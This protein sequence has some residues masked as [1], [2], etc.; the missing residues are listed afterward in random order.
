MMAPEDCALRAS[1]RVLV[2]T[3]PG[4]E[5]PGNEAVWLPADVLARAGSDATAINRS[6]EPT[7]ISR[8]I[9]TDERGGVIKCGCAERGCRLKPAFHC[10]RNAGFSRQLRTHFQSHPPELRHWETAFPPCPPLILSRRAKIMNTRWLLPT[11]LLTTLHPALADGPADN[12]PGRVRRVPPRGIPVAAADRAELETG[13][14]ELGLQIESLRKE[15]EAKPARLDLLAD[16]QIYHKAVRYALAYDEFFNT[17]EISV[18]KALLAQ[19]RERAESLRDGKAPW[20]AATGLV[21]RG[22]TSRID[23]SV[24]PYG[25]VIPPSYQ[26]NTAH[27]F[28]RDWWLHGRGETLREQR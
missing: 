19:G 26:P 18:A 23:G 28:R 25:L 17:N 8:P 10:G 16:A 7:V 3:P 1:E 13:A 22:Y 11:L 21:V 5:K 4:G 9:R 20:L 6:A 12:L 27:Q 14:S 2:K 24:Q 15:L